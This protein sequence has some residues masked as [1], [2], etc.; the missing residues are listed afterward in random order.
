ME[1]FAPKVPAGEKNRRIFAG[2]SS[3]GW[4]GGQAQDI[5][6]LTAHIL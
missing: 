5:S 4:P 2:Q 3:L 1:R 6:T